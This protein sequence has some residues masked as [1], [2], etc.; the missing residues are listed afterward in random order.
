MAVTRDL[1]NDLPESTQLRVS[2]DVAWS[3]IN[4]VYDRDD[5][6]KGNT[7]PKFLLRAHHAASSSQ[8]FSGNL[9]STAGP[10]IGLPGRKLGQGGGHP[11]AI[12]PKKARTGGSCYSSWGLCLTRTLCRRVLVRSS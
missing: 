6:L 12:L 2:D 11:P 10:I 4:G 3:D 8:R 7:N 9:K 5:S 1:T